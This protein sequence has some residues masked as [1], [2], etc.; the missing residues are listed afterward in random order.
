MIFSLII[1]FLVSRFGRPRD[2][3]SDFY[4]ADRTF[5][6]PQN[7]LALFGTFMM[8]TSFLATSDAVALDGY[9]GVLFTAGLAL[10][11]LVAL[12]LVA[13]PLRNTSRYTLGD[14]LSL[15]A[16]ERPVRLAAA[17][18]TLVVFFVFMTV[19]LVGASH[20]LAQ[21]LHLPGPISQALV[22]VAIG[23]LSTVTVYFGGMRATTWTQVI[24]ALLLFAAVVALA[25]L[26][27]VHYRW[28]VSTLLGDAAAKTG[29][30]RMLA[31]GVG[32]GEGEHRL[33]FVSQ[34]MTTVLG[35]AALPYLFIRYLAVP[36]ATH[37]RRSVSWAIWLITPFYLFV[38]LIGFGAAAMVGTDE[39]LPTSGQ[40]GLS[41]IPLL[42]SELGGWPLLA[43]IASVVFTT[44]VAVNA[45]LAL[46]GASSVTRDIYANLVRPLDEAQEV[47]LARR[48]VVVLCLLQTVLAV[49]LMRQNIG[50]L[51]SLDIT[52]VASSILPALLY[53]WF[54]RDFNTAGAL[55]SI[56][57][58]AAA[59][60]VL[61]LVSPAI[62]GDPLALLPDAD[63]AYFPWKS[64]GLV[65]IPIGFLFGYLGARRSPER[66]DAS[67]AAMEVRALTGA[68]AA[69]ALPRDER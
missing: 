27:L 22:I 6:A 21:L 59:V 30:D 48:A 4:T 62:S 36:S 68:G 15:R 52:L 66:D 69:V 18:V 29:G 41:A 19:Q 3:C 28:D 47:G 14:T 16:R 2:T 24:N 49:L 53:S 55:W 17:T 44:I 46:S 25:G 39:L 57:G 32:F 61:V 37:V 11:W 65:S 50:F 12:C 10:S 43:V 8:M 67:F 23:G 64:V 54:W 13:E 56:Y 63:F 26:L 33:E 51:L 45:G 38:V 1:L 7:G 31:P 58:G 5:T 35:Y 34:L 42:A 60:V 9:D 20:L 40:Q